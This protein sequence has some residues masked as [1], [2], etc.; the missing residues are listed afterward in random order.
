MKKL[1]FLLIFALLIALGALPAAAAA[2]DGLPLGQPLEDFSV[3]TID[4]STF[5]LS[6]ALAE[7]DMVLIN[8]WATWCGP[9][10]YE[11]PFLEEAY[12]L[13]QDRV[14]VIALSVER[15]DREDVLTEYAESHGLTF[16]VANESDIGL[17]ETFVTEGIPTTVVVDRFGNVALVEVGSQSSTATFTSL[18]YYFLSDDYTETTVL[19]GMPPIRPNVPDP[20]EAELGEAL[21]AEGGELVFY[22]TPDAY[23]WPMV[24]AEK[25][26]RTVLV[27]SNAGQTYTEAAVCLGLTAEEGDVLVFDVAGSTAALMNKL[28]VYVDGEPA[29]SFSGAFD[30]R[31]WAIPLEAGEHEIVFV[32]CDTDIQGEDEDSVWLDEVRL[33]SGE[34]AQDALDALPVYPVG[35]EFSVSVLN[36]DA[37]E[38]LF[39][40]PDG[41]L[42][43]YFG[44]DSAYIV[45]EGEAAVAAS[46]TEDMDAESMFFYLDYDGTLLPLADSIEDGAYIIRSPIDALD[47]TGYP[48]STVR[49][50][51]RPDYESMDDIRG[52]LLFAD[53]ENLETFTEMLYS[54][55]VYL[56]WTSADGTLSSKAEYTVLF[57]DQNGDPVPGCIVNFCTDETCQPVTADED[58]AA[59]FTGEP[60]PYHLQVIRVPE[61]YEFDLTQEFTADETGGVIELTVTKQ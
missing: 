37:Q 48:Y 51:I 13:Y 23:T 7:K 44:T 38:I 21:N 35:D 25:D 29:K 5:T 36:E 46:I 22:N 41:F 10:E 45:A 49:A 34:E 40:D 50:Y 60:Y 32:Y 14:A 54:M 30:F 17:G 56:T 47:S 53:E 9:C 33:L 27:N 15:A 39:D 4:G 6:E 24:P 1:C 8:L 16:A 3:T 11:F 61:G 52:V 2:G 58:G 55:G 26:G 19:D 43:D 20:T 42:K 59:V 31:T 28:T 12:E 57:T 18:F